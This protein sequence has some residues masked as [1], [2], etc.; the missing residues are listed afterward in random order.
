[1]RATIAERTGV[2]WGVWL[3]C[4]LVLGFLMGATIQ[5]NRVW[6]SNL[7]LWSDAAAKSPLKLRPRVNVARAYQEAGHLEDAFREYQQA[8]LLTGLLSEPDPMRQTGRQLIAMNLGQLYIA[9]GDLEAAEAILVAVWNEEPGF[10]GI[11]LNLAS[12][13]AELGQLTFA[14]ELLDAGLSQIPHYGWFREE[15]KLHFLK[16]EIFRALGNCPAAM[17]SYRLAASLD[18][19]VPAPAPCL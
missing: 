15:G 9:V 14:L 10:P 5:R 2:G 4:L 19:D 18:A 17:E 13:Y 11:A 16:S 1:M 8:W 6:R 7:S 3:V 12:V